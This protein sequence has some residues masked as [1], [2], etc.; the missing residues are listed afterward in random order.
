MSPKK[1]QP[2]LV[3]SR[4]TN[5]SN[6]NLTNK[7]P[8]LLPMVL[9][10]GHSTRTFDEFLSLIKVHGGTLIVDVRTMPRSR[11]NAQFNKET[12]AKSLEENGIGYLHLPALGGLRRP[13][14]DSV[15]KGWRNV[16]FRGY[17]DYM[18]TPQFAQSLDELVTLAKHE[19]P[20]LMCAEAVPWRCHRSLIADALL[21]RGIPVEHIMSATR[22]NVHSLTPFAQVEGAH[23]VYPAIEPA[24]EERKASKK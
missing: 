22:R 24:A 23:I 8:R 21:V 19:R 20:V 15:N 1:S 16:S 3:I 18:Q 2:T 4:E 6:P 7:E 13:L 10:I 9:T 11:H 17:A 12:V 5:A 14:R